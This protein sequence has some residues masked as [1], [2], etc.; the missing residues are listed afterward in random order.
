[1]ISTLPA[2]ALSKITHQKLPTLDELQAVSIMTVN[3]WYPKSN[4]VPNGLG[5]LIPR[6]TPA[7]KNPEHALGVFFDSECIPYENESPSMG[8]E[9]PT[10][11]FVL[12]GGHYYEGKQPPTED[13]A[14]EQAKN[15][16]ERQLGIPRDEPC[17]ATARLA[18]KCLPQH[19]VGH[20][21]RMA[22]LDDEILDTFD[23]RLA[24]AGGSY[25]RPG[26][27]GGLR[28]AWDI[29]HQ[30]SN[31]DFLSNGLEDL[32]PEKVE[33]TG[34]CLVSHE[35]DACKSAQRTS[36]KD[37]AATGTKAEG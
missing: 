7:D 25:N 27:A 19:H 22:L 16:L 31:V 9:R 3:F 18:D 13:E 15:L 36:R 30:V 24:V 12:M 2:H 17:F 34:W 4:L 28:A 21:A 33:K 23:N 37:A 32:V 6:S 11:L 5:Y 1:M 8:D 26:V 35:H 14:I 29:A 10:K 20:A